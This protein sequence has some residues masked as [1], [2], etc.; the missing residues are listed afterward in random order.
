MSLTDLPRL[1]T[2]LRLLVWLGI[3]LLVTM[4]ALVW[5][6]SDL[7][8]RWGQVTADWTWGDRLIAFLLTAP[9]YWVAALGLAQFLGFCRTVAAAAVFTPAAVKSLRRFGGALIAAA[10]LLPPSRLGLWVYI[11][12]EAG[13]EASAWGRVNIG[14]IVLSSG[15]GLVIGLAVLVFASILREAT[16][17]ADEN[18]S[19][20]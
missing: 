2:R 1:A 13:T 19:F 8:P 15:I 3:I 12:F 4:P 6:A 18:A 20:F 14:Q 10:L 17:L 9:P 7:A 16:R 5:L 11:G